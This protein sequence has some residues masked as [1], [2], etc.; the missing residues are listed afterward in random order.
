MS[1]PILS[2]RGVTKFYGA[3]RVIRE[4]DFDVFPGEVLGVLGPN[5]AL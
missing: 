1:D 4:V 3:L 2:G 5:D